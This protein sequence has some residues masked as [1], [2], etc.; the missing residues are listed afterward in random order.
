MAKNNRIA[1]ANRAW[2]VDRHLLVLN[3]VSSPGAGKTTLLERT[4]R[5]GADAWPWAVIEGDQQTD[6][7]ARRIAACGVPV[8][9]INTGT[10]CHLDAEMVADACRRLDPAPGAVVMIENVGNL[11]C[12]ALF[13]LGEAARVV[14]ASV[15]DGDDKPAKYPYMFETADLVVLN[16]CD[17]LQYVQFDAERFQTVLDEVIPTRRFFPSRQRAATRFSP[18][19]AGLPSDTP[20]PRERVTP[21]A[22]DVARGAHDRSQTVGDPD[23]R[24]RHGDSSPP[25]T[26]RR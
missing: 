7:D 9:Q 22:G 15:T 21:G 10:M 2:F 20:A 17:L 5:H 6:N 16:K 4:L 25:T 13:D 18:G 8:V 24:P 26:P 19:T 12:P 1:A 3:L 11:V 23:R 14:V